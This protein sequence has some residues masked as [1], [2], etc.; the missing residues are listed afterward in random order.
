MVC[1]VT[2]QDQW[3]GDLMVEFSDGGFDYANP[4][5]LSPK[6]D[7][8]GETF[9]DP[10]DAVDA[11][12]SIFNEWKADEPGADISI[13]YG[14][15]LGFTMPFESSSVPEIK[16]WAQKDYDALP[17]CDRCGEILPEEFYFIDDDKYCS[18]YCCDMVFES[19]Y[20]DIDEE[21]L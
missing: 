11:A 5:M 3:M 15:T 1:T 21:E 16:A 10:R 12:I 8:E 4:D 14:A 6:Y 17:K 13:G 9:I 2:R 20:A 18:E 7:G 19:M